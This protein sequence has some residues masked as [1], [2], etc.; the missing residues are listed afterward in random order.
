MHAVLGNPQTLR[1]LAW[2]K[3]LNVS[4]V[5]WIEFGIKPLILRIKPLDSQI[6]P[7]NSP[8]KPLGSQFKPLDLIIKPL[9]LCI[10][11]IRGQPEPGKYRVKPI[12]SDI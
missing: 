4:N 11:E 9:N 12:C 1:R 6:K 10:K 3:S 5:S 8:I 2:K 7:L